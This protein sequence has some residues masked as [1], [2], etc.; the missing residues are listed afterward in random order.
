MSSDCEQR[1]MARIGRWSLGILS[2]VAALTAVAATNW[3]IATK[4]IEG[5]EEA[6]ADQKEWGKTLAVIEARLASIEQKIDRQE[7][8]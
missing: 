2:T 3:A 8:R 6:E 7:N 4:R 1:I 5:L